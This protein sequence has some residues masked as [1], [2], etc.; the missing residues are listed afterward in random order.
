MTLTA[1]EL[2]Q[3]IPVKLHTELFDSQDSNNLEFDSCKAALM[4][5]RSCRSSQLATA[6]RERRDSIDRT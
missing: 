6:K 3:V 5:K 4:F 2:S 1:P